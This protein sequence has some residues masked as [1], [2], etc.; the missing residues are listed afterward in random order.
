M[1]GDGSETGELRKA[2]GG[3]GIWAEAYT[4]GG[5]AGLWELILSTCH[6]QQSP[7][8]LQPQ[9]LASS[10]EKALSLSSGCLVSF[11][12]HSLPQLLIVYVWLVS[13]VEESPGS[14]S[15]STMSRLCVPHALV[16]GLYLLTTT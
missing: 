16:L 1:T 8:R 15:A 13:M 12:P 6:L 2:P 9:L 14:N 11:R 4:R 5:S 3:Q 7:Q 10:F